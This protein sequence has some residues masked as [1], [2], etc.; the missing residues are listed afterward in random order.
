MGKSSSNKD[1]MRL[2]GK[3]WDKLNIPED[4]VNWDEEDME[5]YDDDDG[6]EEEE[7]RGPYWYVMN[8]IAGK[9]LGLL[10]QALS[11]ERELATKEA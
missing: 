9:E 8:C 4:I 1:K 11:I 2:Y 5:A 6:D 10:E 3:L 7:D